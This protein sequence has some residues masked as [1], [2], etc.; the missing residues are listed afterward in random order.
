MCHIVENTFTHESHGKY[1]QNILLLDIKCTVKITNTV[2]S[3]TTIKWDGNNV[4]H[5]E[6][7]LEQHNIYPLH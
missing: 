1:M 2:I 7:T 6:I 4:Y 3:N 5:N